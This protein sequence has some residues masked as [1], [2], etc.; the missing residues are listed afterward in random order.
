V[1]IELKSVRRHAADDLK[2]SHPTVEE[3]IEAEVGAR[4]RGT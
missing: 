4:G 2:G 1:V 3:E